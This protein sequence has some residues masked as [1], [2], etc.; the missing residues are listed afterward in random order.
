MNHGEACADTP[1]ALKRLPWV[2]AGALALAAPVGYD[3]ASLR[4]P[5]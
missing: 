1:H 4:E 3:P 2:A 5:I